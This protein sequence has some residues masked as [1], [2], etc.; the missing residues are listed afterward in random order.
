MGLG[1]SK[2]N[3]GLLALMPILFTNGC[4]AAV[5]V[6]KDKNDNLPRTMAVYR[7]VSADGSLSFSDIPPANGKFKRLTYDCFACRPSS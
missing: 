3:K 1:L 2:N 7:S 6:S 5:E 4:F